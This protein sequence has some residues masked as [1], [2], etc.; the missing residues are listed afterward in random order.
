MYIIVSYITSSDR[1]SIHYDQSSA[2]GCLKKKIKGIYV[3]LERS[4]DVV[5][6]FLTK[7]VYTPWSTICGQTKIDDIAVIA[8]LSK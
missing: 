2:L 8:V 4:V 3:L 5:I 6:S 7:S 1:G